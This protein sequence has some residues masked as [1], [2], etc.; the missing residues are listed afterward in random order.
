MKK[1]FLKVN[2]LIFGVQGWDPGSGWEL[3]LGS[4]WG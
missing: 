1:R 4:D 2:Y 3:D